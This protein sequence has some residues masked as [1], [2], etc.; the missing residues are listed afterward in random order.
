[1]SNCENCEELQSLLDDAIIELREI[2]EER[3][4]AVKR[5]DE[6]EDE[7]LR[8][9]DHVGDVIDARLR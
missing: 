9:R 8:V 4:E 2:G 3:D 1:M 5:V 7:L 6:L